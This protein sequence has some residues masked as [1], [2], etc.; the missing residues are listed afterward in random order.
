M[1]LIGW[2]CR[3]LGNSCTVNA[4]K[5]AIRLENPKIVFLMETKSNRDWMEKI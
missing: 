3:G 2:N 1:N 5:E 4:L